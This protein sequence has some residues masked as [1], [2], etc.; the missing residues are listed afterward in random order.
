MEVDLPDRSFKELAAAG[1]APAAV[2]S[3][4]VAEVAVAVKPR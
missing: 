3:K 2:G 1:V 4:A